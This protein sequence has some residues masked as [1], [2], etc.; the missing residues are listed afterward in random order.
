MQIEETTIRTFR[1]EDQEA[2]RAL[3]LRGLAERWG[4]LDETMNPDLDN[5]AR[6]YTDG[7]FLVAVSAGQIVASGALIP[8]SEGVGRIVRMSV[9]RS[10]RRQ[11]LGRR[12]L[13]ALCERARAVGYR[14]LVL[15]TTAT[16]ADAIAFYRAH[17]FRPL[18]E[19]AGD[20]HFVL[21]LEEA[22]PSR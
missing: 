10:R 13:Y 17:G 7:V 6:H 5:I 19:R 20:M 4:E 8:E 18:G 1:P 3:I 15:E 16:W 12:M 14:Q 11:G 2:A 9:A 21:E 22:F